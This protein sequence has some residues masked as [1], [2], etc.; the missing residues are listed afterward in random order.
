MAHAGRRTR[1][2]QETKPSR[3]VTEI[4]FTD[5]F[6]C[7]GTSKIDIERFVGDAH[8]TA[9]QLERSA[10]FAEHY[11]VVLEAARWMLRS[12]TG[13]IFRRRLSRL[14]PANESFPQQANGTQIIFFSGGEISPADRARSNFSRQFRRRVRA[15]KRPENRHS[16]HHPSFSGHQGFAE[17]M[18]LGI[19]L[20]RVQTVHS[21]CSRTS[22]AYSCADGVSSSLPNR[23]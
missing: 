11:F 21:I 10:V 3:L 23:R 2:A 4:F 9:T 22:N 13:D 6:Q 17:L 18:N 16:R 8:R 12:R 7:H 19:D 5:D 15:I 14:R 1:F 20:V